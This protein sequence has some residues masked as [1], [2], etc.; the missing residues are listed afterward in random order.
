MTPLSSS[1]LSLCPLQTH[2]EY[3]SPSQPLTSQGQSR[4]N[5]PQDTLGLSLKLVS[6]GFLG[7]YGLGLS[8]CLVIVELAIGTAY[9]LFAA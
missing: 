3:S 5:Y 9:C 7:F 2:L 4:P 8:H 1:S 6:T